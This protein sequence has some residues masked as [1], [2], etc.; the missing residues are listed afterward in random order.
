MPQKIKKF[1]LSPPREPLETR[2]TAKHKTWQK[3]GIGVKEQP[4]LRVTVTEAVG[5]E[6]PPAAQHRADPFA[7]VEG[8]AAGG[9]QGEGR[10]QWRSA[11][12]SRG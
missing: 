7:G 10:A 6:L 12:N 1:F 2:G 3:C 9:R 5:L 4:A 8:E 11:G